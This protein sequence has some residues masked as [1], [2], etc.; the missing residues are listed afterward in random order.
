LENKCDQSNFNI[1][2]QITKYEAMKSKRD[3]NE[4]RA[5]QME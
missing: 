2:E 5:I 4:V 3:G 1:E